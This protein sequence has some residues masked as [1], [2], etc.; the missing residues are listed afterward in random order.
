MRSAPLLA[1]PLLAAPLLAALALGACADPDVDLGGVSD[2]SDTD[3]SALWGGETGE[4]G[5]LEWWGASAGQGAAGGEER[6]EAAL[7]EVRFGAVCAPGCL[8]SAYA[9]TS[10]AQQAEATCE[11]FL[12]ACVV[13]GDASARCEPNAPAPEGGA[14]GG[15][16]P[17]PTPAPAPTDYNVDLGRRLADAAYRQASRRNTVGYCYSAVA[18]AVESV[19]GAFLYGASAYMA[20]DQFA[21]HPRFREERVS[22]LRALP[23]GA[24]VVWGRGTSAHG[25]ISVALGDGREASDHIAPQMLWH[26]GGAPARVFSPR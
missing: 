4:G 2:P 19:V 3:K 6:A 20:A 16:G 26:Y 17:S 8:W 25:H 18:D 24:V 9:V 12:C 23:A 14:E 1:V 15:A 22:D 21:R 10:G 7:P 13:S 5:A 11:G